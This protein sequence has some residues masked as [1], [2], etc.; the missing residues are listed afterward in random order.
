ML[1]TQKPSGIIALHF[2]SLLLMALLISCPG[3]KPPA[4][5]SHLNH[6]LGNYRTY[7]AASAVLGSYGT[8]RQEGTSSSFVWIDTPKWKAIP[9]REV[10]SVTVDQSNYQLLESM[11]IN[12]PA[13][14][15]IIAGAYGAQ[16]ES[17]TLVF[18]ELPSGPLVRELT[19]MLEKDSQLLFELGAPD[20]RIVT[21]AGMVLDHKMSAQFNALG[22][23]RGQLR[24]IGDDSVQIELAT[25]AGHSQR[26]SI[27]DRTIVSYQLARFCWDKETGSL[28]AIRR[29]QRGIEKSCP[30]GSVHPR[31]KRF[32]KE[33]TGNG[34]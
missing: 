26:I 10:T 14:L 7:G 33:D 3:R 32:T 9:L 6:L 29:D 25:Q 13:L 16:Q 23:I 30:R 22:R 19:G 27:G 15:K 5:A 11:G 18:L 8:K 2:A 17:F 12:V 28:R 34:A 21:Q 31:P 1:G 24:S 4:T 20:A